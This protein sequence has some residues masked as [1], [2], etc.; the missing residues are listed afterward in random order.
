MAGAPDTV[1]VVAPVTVTGLV[2][3]AGNAGRHVHTR[4]RCRV[5]RR[6]CRRARMRRQAVTQAAARCAGVAAALHMT[7]RITSR[8]ARVK[9]SS[10]AVTGSLLT[11]RIRPRAFTGMR[12]ARPR[13]GTRGP[14]VS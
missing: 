13:A 11:S 14:W 10:R 5:A 4:G 7:D 2:L 8:R 3:G 12:K 9:D 6:G 1:M